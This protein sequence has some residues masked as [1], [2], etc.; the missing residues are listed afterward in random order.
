MSATVSNYDATPKNVNEGLARS[1]LT[2]RL[3]LLSS[4]ATFDATHTVITQVSNSGANEVY[5]NGWPQ[6]G[7][8]ISLVHTVEDTDKGKITFAEIVQT[9]TG[10]SLTYQR[11]CLYE[12]DGGVPLWWWTLPSSKTDVDGSDVVITPAGS[13]VYYHTATP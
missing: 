4:T 8:P 3:M 6:G 2:H 12:F 10:G 9:L 5:G 11:M 13:G 7:S 1:A